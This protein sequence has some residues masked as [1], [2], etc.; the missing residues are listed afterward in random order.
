MLIK[1]LGIYLHALIGLI[2][3]PYQ[4]ALRRFRKNKS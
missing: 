4:L 1:L 2:S 3:S